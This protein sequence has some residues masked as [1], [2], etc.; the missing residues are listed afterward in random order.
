M[1]AEHDRHIKSLEDSSLTSLFLEYVH[2]PINGSYQAK[3]K[4]AAKRYSNYDSLGQSPR[5][6]K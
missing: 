6:N 1:L 5:M 4:N 2:L 3:T